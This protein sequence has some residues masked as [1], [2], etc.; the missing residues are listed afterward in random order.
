MPWPAKL[1]QALPRLVWICLVLAV[2]AYGGVV[3]RN[4]TDMLVGM[5][6]HQQTLVEVQ[7]PSR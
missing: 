7:R 3:V 4:I 2:A 6:S 5:T 1:R